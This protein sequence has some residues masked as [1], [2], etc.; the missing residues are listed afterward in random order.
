M[1]LET[2]TCVVHIGT[3]DYIRGLLEVIAERVLSQS[4]PSFSLKVKR[5]SVSGCRGL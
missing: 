5:F 4:H 1:I 2:E 3:K